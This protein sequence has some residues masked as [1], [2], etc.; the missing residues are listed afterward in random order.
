[1]D[2]HDALGGNDA[3]VAG[4]WHRLCHDS[5][6]HVGRAHHH[7]GGDADRQS[8]ALRL[9]HGRRLSRLHSRQRRGA[10]PCRIAGHRHRG[11]DGPGRGAR[12]H[13]LSLG[14]CHRRSRADPD[15]HRPHLHHGGERQSGLRL[16]PESGADS[17]IPHHQREFRRHQHFRLSRRHHRGQHGDRRR[18]VGDPRI[19]G[20]RRA[21]ARRG[22]QSAHGALRRHRRAARVL[23]HLRGRLRPC[24]G[25]GVFGQPAPAARAVVCA[26]ISRAAC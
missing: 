2:R 20:F 17:A 16:Q 9:R 12:A 24:R 19:H 4:R 11:D 1:M 5:V 13:G 6:P 23:H 22:R 18:V 8:R 26:G 10:R 14:L 15:D 21:P 25:G 7:A 3:R